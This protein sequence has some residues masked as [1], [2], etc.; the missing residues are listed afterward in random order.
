[1]LSFIRPVLA[2][3]LFSLGLAAIGCSDNPVTTPP[4]DHFEAV[5]LVLVRQGIDSVVV[6]SAKVRGSLAV[7]AGDSTG[8]FDIF[9]LRE[10]TRARDLPTDDAFTLGWT[11]ADTSVVAL[12]LPASDGHTHQHFEFRLVGKKAGTTTVVLRLLHEGHDDYVTPPI[13]VTVTP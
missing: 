7:G 6:D 2:L 10:D 9:F 13:P 12:A 5:G 8:Y 1:M 3:T 11:I 4:A